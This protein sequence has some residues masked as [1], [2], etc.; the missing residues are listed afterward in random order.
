MCINRAVTRSSSERVATRPIVDRQTPV[1]ILPSLAVGNYNVCL[2]FGIWSL[3]A[4]RKLK[5]LQSSNF[6]RTSAQNAQCPTH[7]HKCSITD[8]QLC[9]HKLSK[10]MTHPFSDHLREMIYTD[11]CL[12][13][14]TEKD[15]IIFPLL[16]VNLWVHKRQMVMKVHSRH[17]VRFSWN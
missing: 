11:E 8:G 1:K 12:F 15:E 9:L 10:Q 17:D 16:A 14:M 4:R 5:W 3:D 13:S 2:W 7:G 6:W